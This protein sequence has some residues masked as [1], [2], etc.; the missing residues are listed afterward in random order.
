[1]KYLKIV[2]AAMLS[3]P[4]NAAAQR[5]SAEEKWDGYMQFGSKQKSVEVPN[6]VSA[7]PKTGIMEIEVSQGLQIADK[8]MVENASSCTIELMA[9]T[10]D[11][12][13]E[14]NFVPFVST[15]KVPAG[16]TKLVQDFDGK[17]R[18]LRGGKLRIKIKGI[19]STTG[20]ATYDFNV[21]L[22][23]KKHDLYIKVG[24]ND[25]FNF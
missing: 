1:M 15:S 7:D 6:T 20:N 22:Y 19:D 14:G 3:F 24:S 13:G 21:T 2:I 5:G 4:Y 18:M 11:Y 17:L 8:V 25:A 12:I 16:D 9:V 10:V 23:E